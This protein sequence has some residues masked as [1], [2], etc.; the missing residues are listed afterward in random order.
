[1]THRE[2]Y[3]ELVALLEECG[4]LQLDTEWA[5]P[6]QK[7]VERHKKPTPEAIDALREAGMLRND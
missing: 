2:K 5:E 3:R 6:V 1:M 4:V 7:M